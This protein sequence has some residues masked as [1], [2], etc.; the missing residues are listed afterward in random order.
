MTKTLSFQIYIPTFAVYIIESRELPGFTAAI[1]EYE[2]GFV[3][4]DKHGSEAYGTLTVTIKPNGIPTFLDCE[5]M[6]NYDDLLVCSCILKTQ[7]S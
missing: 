1:L 2:I 5:Y 4:G 3:C 7:K 6:K